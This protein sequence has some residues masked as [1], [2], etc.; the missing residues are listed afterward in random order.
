MECGE[1]KTE[2]APV[3]CLVLKKK[4]KKS[5]FG[6]GTKKPLGMV[7]A[8]FPLFDRQI[9]LIKSS[10]SLWPIFNVRTVRVKVQR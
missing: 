4:K 10:I 2:D 5:K 3:V 6:I 1:A 7:F 8:L 9:L